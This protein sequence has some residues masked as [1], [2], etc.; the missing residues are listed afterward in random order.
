MVGAR[1]GRCELALTGKFEGWK[2]VG[3]LRMKWEYVKYFRRIGG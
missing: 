1:H 3:N 2:P